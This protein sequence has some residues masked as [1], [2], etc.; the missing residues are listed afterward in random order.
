VKLSEQLLFMTHLTKD[1]LT[2]Q[3]TLPPVVQQQAACLLQAHALQG[4]L[5]M[6][7]IIPNVSP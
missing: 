5:E 2:V 4:E 7:K 6:P 3:S 1:V